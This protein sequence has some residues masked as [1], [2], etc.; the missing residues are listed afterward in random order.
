VSDVTDFRQGRR[1][2]QIDEGAQVDNTANVWHLAHIR[3]SAVVGAETIIGRAAYVG[4]GVVIGRRCKVQNLAQIFE[5]AVLEDG[6]FVGPGAILTNDRRP[7]AVNP[8]GSLKSTSD[9]EPVGVFV[10]NGASIGAGAICVAPIR[11]GR[12]AMIAAGAVLVS[13]AKSY[14]LYMGAP[15]R[16]VGWVGP[17]GDRLVESGQDSFRCPSTGQRFLLSEE[18]LLNPLP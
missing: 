7:R 17:A 5:P 10:E 13:D 3:S 9:W 16:Q 15:A 11:V 14:G 12:W 1:E 8:D 18:G 2:G 6:V 4:S